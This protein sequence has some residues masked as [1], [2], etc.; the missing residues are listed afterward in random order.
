M[1]QINRITASDLDM[2]IQKIGWWLEEDERYNWKRSTHA[3]EYILFLKERFP[4][5]NLFLLPTI[6]TNK[7]S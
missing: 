1:W 5:W 4:T 6:L 2:K 7:T 3:A